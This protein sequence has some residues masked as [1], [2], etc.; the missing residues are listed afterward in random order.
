MPRRNKIQGRSEEIEGRSDLYSV[1][2]LLYKMLTGMLPF[3]SDSFADMIEK[4]TLEKPPAPRLYNKK[5]PHDFQTII[6]KAIEKQKQDRYASA[7]EFRED[8]KRFRRGE[9]ILAEL[10]SRWQLAVRKLNRHAIPLAIGFI[11]FWLILISVAYLGMRVHKGIRQREAQARQETLQ[12]AQRY[13]AQQKF[14]QAVSLAQEVLVKIPGDQKALDLIGKAKS[15]KRRTLEKLV[16]QGRDFVNRQDWRHAIEVLSKAQSLAPDDAG[17][18]SLLEFAKLDK[19]T[20]KFMITPALAKW[21]IFDVDEHT[22]KI[23]DQPLATGTADSV[24][25]PLKAYYLLEFN[26]KSY[27]PAR[28]LLQRGNVKISEVKLDLLAARNIPPNMVYIP[29]TQVMLGSS[30]RVKGIAAL[31][32]RLY[33]IE[34]FCID[35]FE[36]TNAQYR[37]YLNKSNRYNAD[38]WPDHWIEGRIP[39][40]LENH[41]VYN[42]SWRKAHDYALYYNKKLP[43]SEQ[44]ELAAVATDGRPYPWGTVPPDNNAVQK[45]LSCLFYNSTVSIGSMK[46]DCSPLW[47]NGFSR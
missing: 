4:V 43:T 39:A 2:I 30:I 34:P 13:I 18:K 12:R 31:P 45:S 9:P 21:S 32:Y 38:Y 22:R 44:W 3:S 8:L 16:K 6:L 47:R 36:V 37:Q 42:I 35:K 27:L 10:P 25:L 23:A 29:E 5:I 1:G 40:G 15:Q 19:L 20:I 24:S 7:D 11:V 41:P 28:T 14:A 33:T 26:C 17:V 46:Q